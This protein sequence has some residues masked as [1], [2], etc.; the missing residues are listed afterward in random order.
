[1]QFTKEYIE[2]CQAA[3]PFLQKS[4]L[5]I[6]DYVWIPDNLLVYNLQL[7]VHCYD[8]VYLCI[9][10][11]LRMDNEMV[12]L[13]T[14]DQLQD[15]TLQALKIDLYELIIKFETYALSDDYYDTFQELWLEFVMLTV[16]NHFWD[17]TKKK[18]V[19]SK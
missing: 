7:L 11:F 13:P 10:E 1:M 15:Y 17:P 6:G 9:T 2:M 19:Q 14:V 12:W 5:S 4:S 18:W 16:H 3:R 8:K